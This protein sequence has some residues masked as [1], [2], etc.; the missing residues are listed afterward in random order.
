MAW[1]PGVYPSLIYHGHVPSAPNLA[2]SVMWV[3]L[4]NDGSGNI[5]S[6]TGYYS[7][8]AVSDGTLQY[9]NFGNLG[10]NFAGL[11]AAPPRGRT[12]TPT[13]IAT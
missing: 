8:E 11:P 7:G 4:S 6:P 3:L 10:D 9:D 13:A 2:S 1:L 12:W 5:G